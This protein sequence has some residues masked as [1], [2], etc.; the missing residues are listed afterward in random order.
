MVLSAPASEPNAIAIARGQP[1]FWIRS[2]VF[3]ACW[4]K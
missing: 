2:D 3:D 4:A 1:S